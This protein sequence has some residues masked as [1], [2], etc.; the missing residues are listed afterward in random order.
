VAT[1]AQALGI[2]ALLFVSAAGA[3]EV[4]P[5]E[6]EITLV[7]LQAQASREV[8]NDQLVA[9]L[10]VELQGADPAMLAE[11]VNAALLPVALE[12]GV[13]Q[14]TVTVSGSIQVR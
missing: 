5:R 9:V 14:V 6:R 11:A 13:S 3:Q 1:Q 12:A 7:N 2:A 4:T 8:E 10:A